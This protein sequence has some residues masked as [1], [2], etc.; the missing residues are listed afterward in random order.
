MRPSSRARRRSSPSR[1]RRSRPRSCPPLDD[2]L[3]AEAGFDT[4]DELREDIR[5][6]LREADEQRI[7][8]EFR[9]TVLDAAVAGATV[10]GTRKGLRLQFIDHGPGIADVE[11]AM[12]D[13]WTSGRGMGLGLSGSKRLVNDFHIATVPGQ[14]TTVTIA[15]W[16]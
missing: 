1:S 14:G 7:E 10:E 3:A 4:L 5:A 13:G 12:K 16:K 15:R 2:D 11:L 6:R 9:E 8:A